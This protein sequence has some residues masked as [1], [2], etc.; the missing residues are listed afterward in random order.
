MEV[1]IRRAE[2]TDVP[3]MLALVKELAAFEREPEA[4]VVTEA[5][6]IEAGFGEKPVWF[7]WVAEIH[8]ASEGATSGELVGAAI[9][10]ERYSTWKGRCLYL[11]DLVVKE[12]A[13]RQQIGERLFTACADH[14]RS[15]DFRLMTWQVLDWNVDAIRFYERLGAEIGSGWLNGILQL[16]K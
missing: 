1:I 15:R 12:N 11:E 9:C 3:A 10:Y 14:A 13:R 16:K 4:V 6:M 8:V 5:E 2:A 7:G